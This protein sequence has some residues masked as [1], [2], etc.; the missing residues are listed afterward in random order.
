MSRPQIIL[1]MWETIE[2]LQFCAARLSLHRNQ[3]TSIF[4]P[5]AFLSRIINVI[6]FSF[7]KASDNLQLVLSILRII[8]INQLSK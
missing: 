5:R 1:E 7:V 2:D 8:Q 4:F 3:P 6:F